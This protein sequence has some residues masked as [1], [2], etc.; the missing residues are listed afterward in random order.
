VS[1]W[2]QAS[3]P[4]AT[5]VA[6]PDERDLGGA[7][8][9]AF[10]LW[11][12]HAFLVWNHVFVPLSYKLDLSIMVTDVLELL[13]VLLEQ[14]SGTHTIAW[15]SNSFRVDWT[16]EWEGDRLVVRAT[17]DTTLG[18]VAPLLTAAGD[19]EVG[20]GAFLAEWRAVLDRLHDGLTACGYT[21][22][23]VAGMADLERVRTRLPATGVLYT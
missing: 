8:E 14:D 17:W 10:P 12:E 23:T 21:A 19:L 18:G 1:F 6:D 15:P 11:A 2:I 3:A 13:D 4:R 16:L 5:G 7:I 20:R 9:T 22:D